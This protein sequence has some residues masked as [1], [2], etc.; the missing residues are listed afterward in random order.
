M[1]KSLTKL[2]PVI[3]EDPKEY[4]PDTPTNDRKKNN[5]WLT[6]TGPAVSKVK[7]NSFLNNEAKD[8]DKIEVDEE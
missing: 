7:I 5:Q 4:M 2:G 1:F 3:Y 6:N 8:T